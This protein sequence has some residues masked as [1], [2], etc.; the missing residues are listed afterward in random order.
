MVGLDV[1]NELPRIAADDDEQAVLFMQLIRKMTFENAL[2]KTFAGGRWRNVVCTTE[3][4]SIQCGDD[5][6]AMS[7]LHQIESE[8][9]V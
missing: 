7:R 4:Q 3:V 2:D 5:P 6:V 1:V 8:F 9:I